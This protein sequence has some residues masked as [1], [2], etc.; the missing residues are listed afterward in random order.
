MPLYP[1]RK[2]KRWLYLTCFSTPRAG[3]GTF[4][5]DN[6]PWSTGPKRTHLPTCCLLRASPT[7]STAR[8]RRPRAPGSDATAIAESSASSP[9]RLALLAMPGINAHTARNR[10]P[11]TSNNSHPSP[12]LAAVTASSPRS[13]QH[14]CSFAVCAFLL[15]LRLRLGPFLFQYTMNRCEARRGERHVSPPY[16]T[17]ARP[18]SSYDCATYRLLICCD[19]RTQEN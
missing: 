18:R 1:I 12:E 7:G 8:R 16:Q 6:A 11:R 14:C 19:L 5:F 3:H 2:R 13:R 17:L 9:T 15:L 10:M 4:L